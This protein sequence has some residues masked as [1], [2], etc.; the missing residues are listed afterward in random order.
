MAEQEQQI[1][2]QEASLQPAA[3]ETEEL[4]PGRTEE[5]QAAVAAV[6]VSAEA[7]GAAAE[8]FEVDVELDLYQTPAQ[9]KKKPGKL[10]SILGSNL[11]SAPPTG[12]QQ[13]CSPAAGKKSRAIAS[14]YAYEVREADRSRKIG[15]LPMNQQLDIMPTGLDIARD[16]HT[17]LQSQFNASGG[18]H[19]VSKGV[20]WD[21]IMGN[22]AFQKRLQFLQEHSRTGTFIEQYGEDGMYEGDFMHGMRHGKGRYEFRK[23]VYDSGRPL[24][25][26]LRST[27]SSRASGSW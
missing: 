5:P 14:R 11:S 13:P 19:L 2:T 26:R 21:A 7:E 27:P 3:L 24:D 17:D 12:Q 15:Y 25:G 4:Q 8:A 1:E 18:A 10:P 9:K 6:D 22:D 16:M 23:E 20:G